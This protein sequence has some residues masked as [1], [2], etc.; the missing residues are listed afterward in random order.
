M[1]NIVYHSN[2]HGKIAEVR[3]KIENSPIL[4][5]YNDKVKIG[6]YPHLKTLEVNH[7]IKF[8]KDDWG[9]YTDTYIITVILE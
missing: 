7:E 6:E 1:Y 3:R 2:T 4:P 5:R 8:H 9:Q